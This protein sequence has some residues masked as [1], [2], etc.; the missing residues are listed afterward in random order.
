V[1]RNPIV[2]APEEAKKTRKRTCKM[3]TATIIVARVQPGTSK[4]ITDLLLPQPSSVLKRSAVPLV[5]ALHSA[6]P[7][8]YAFSCCLTLFLRKE[9]KQNNS[10]KS[11]NHEAAIHQK[12]EGR[13]Q[14]VAVTF[15]IFKVHWPCSLKISAD[16]HMPESTR[17]SQKKKANTKAFKNL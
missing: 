4:G 17:T 8:D 2:F 6:N 1:C 5:K 16:A 15:V 14:G 11:K 13:Q 3:L 12:M 10:Q 9:K 7:H